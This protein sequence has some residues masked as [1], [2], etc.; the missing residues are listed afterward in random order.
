MAPSNNQTATDTIQIHQKIEI[1]IKEIKI[2]E[3]GLEINGLNINLFYNKR[4]YFYLIKL[5]YKNV[6]TPMI[7]TYV[8][9]QG[10]KAERS[11]A[12]F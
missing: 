2:I 1:R 10:G 5:R 3:N 7:Y 6:K 11:P 4:R 9:I 12:D 8:T